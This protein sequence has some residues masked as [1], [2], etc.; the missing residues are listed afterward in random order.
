LKYINLFFSIMLMLL[1]NSLKIML[2]RASGATIGKGCRIGF[3]IIDARKIILGDFVQIGS[4]NLVH[5]LVCLECEAGSRIGE[6]NWITGGGSGS[7]SLGVCA[8][9]TRLHFFEASASIWVGANTIVAG[10]SSH[11]FTHGISSVNLDDMRPIK[12]G[13]WS[14]IGSSSRF[15]PGSGTAEGTFVGMGSVVTKSI[16]DSFVLLAGAP[17]VV[18]RQLSATDI[19]FDRPFLPHDHHPVGFRPG[20]THG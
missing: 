17:A 13:P 11:F 5:R 8:A 10:R 18:R 16:E 19:Y 20:E 6:F 15:T 9:V 14:Y 4:F 12:I 3:S 2:L 7:L 1:P